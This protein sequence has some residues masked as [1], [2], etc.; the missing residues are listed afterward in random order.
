MVQA[1]IATRRRAPSTP[2]TIIP[3]WTATGKSFQVLEAERGIEAV[4]VL[5]SVDEVSDAEETVASMELRSDV[6]VLL[7]LLL[8]LLVVDPETEVGDKALSDATAL[9]EPLPEAVADGR[10]S[11]TNPT[12]ESCRSRPDLSVPSTILANSVLV[13]PSWPS[14]SRPQE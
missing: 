6:G 8:S 1:I 9:L 10:L 4:A 11:T 3:T 2:P 7:M 5:D 12:E 14:E 13:T